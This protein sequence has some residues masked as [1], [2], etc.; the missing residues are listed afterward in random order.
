[1]TNLTHNYFLCIYFNSLHVS[2]NLLLII[3]RINCIN[4]TSGICHSVSVAVSCA[5]RK[6]KLSN[7][8][9]VFWAYVCGL[10]HPAHNAHVPYCHLWPVLLYNIFP[11]Y[12]IKGT[13]FEKQLLNIKCV[14]WFSVQL[15]YETFF[16]LRRN[17]WEVTRS[18]HWSPCTVPVI[19][20]RS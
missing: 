20:V 12:L 7:K 4:T 14:L 11:H 2:S 16:I 5:V 3:R 1:M 18:V 9:Y 13:V 8:Y 17:E 6:G 15:L 10:M 19:L